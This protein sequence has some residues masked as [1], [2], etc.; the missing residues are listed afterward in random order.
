MVISTRPCNYDD[1]RKENVVD[2]NS[3]VCVTLN[4]RGNDLGIRL[5][6]FRD[7]PNRHMHIIANVYH[8]KDDKGYL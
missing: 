7:R 2:M 5:N 1:A 8:D 6:V 4:Y 3:L